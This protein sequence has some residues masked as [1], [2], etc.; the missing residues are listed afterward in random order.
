MVWL[1]IAAMYGRVLRYGIAVWSQV[2]ASGYIG[3]RMREGMPPYLYMKCIRDSSLKRYTFMY[4]VKYVL[5][6]SI[7]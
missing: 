2:I 3:V 1:G 5:Y 4:I 7:N 6:Q